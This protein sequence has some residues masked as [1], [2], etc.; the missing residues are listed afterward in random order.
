MDTTQMRSGRL[1]ARDVMTSPVIT[2]SPEVDVRDVAATMLAHHI[3]GLPVVTAAGELVGIV[4]EGD[5]VHKEA[6]V[7]HGKQE[8]LERVKAITKTADKARG[9]TARELMTTPVVTVDE[10]TPLRETVSLMVTRQINRVPVMREA[11]LVGIVT[12]ADALRALV[13][14]DEEI[15]AAVREILRQGVWI[16]LSTLRFWVRNGVVHLEGELGSRD[17]KELAERRIGAVDGVV[18]I[19]SRVSYGGQSSGTAGGGAA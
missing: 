13:R 11:Q 14:P 8:P 18:E 10:D 3:S 2:V 7:P 17:E 5:L 4:T 1:R 16:D 19:E 15:A 9:V 6:P 12:R